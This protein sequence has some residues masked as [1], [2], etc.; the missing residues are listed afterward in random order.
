MAAKVRPIGLH[1]IRHLIASTLL[2][3]GYG[4]HEVAERLGHDSATL[5]RYYARVSAARRLQATDWIAELMTEPE[6]Q[7]RAL[8]NWAGC[9]TSLL[10]SRVCGRSYA[11][12]EAR[13]PVSVCTRPRARQKDRIQNSPTCGR[14]HCPGQ[15]EC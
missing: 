2:H 14:W 1:R 10:P 4:V 13:T 11:P 7:P 8:P 12:P 3:A 6:I 9:A 15:V 5:M